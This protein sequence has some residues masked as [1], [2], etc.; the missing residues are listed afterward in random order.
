MRQ[1]GIYHMHILSHEPLVCNHSRHSSISSTY[2]SI[3]PLS[4]QSHISSAYF[5]IQPLS[6]RCNDTYSNRSSTYCYIRPLTIQSYEMCSNRS[7]MYCYVWPLNVRSYEI[8]GN[9]TNI[10]NSTLVHDYMS[11][12]CKTVPFLCHSQVP[13]HSFYFS[14]PHHWPQPSYWPFN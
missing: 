10:Q 14:P 5:Y 6:S 7:Y 2:W 11:V 1:V 13:S 12:H 4:F 9:I 3:R 8:W